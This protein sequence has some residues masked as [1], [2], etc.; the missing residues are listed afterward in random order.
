MRVPR[1]D[2]KHGV[3]DI[4]EMGL[5]EI[6]SKGKREKRLK[7]VIFFAFGLPV[8]ARQTGLSGNCV[9]RSQIW[10]GIRESVFQV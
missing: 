10:P 5:D 7:Q 9:Y 6:H 4:C 3:A 8:P 2:P 1:T